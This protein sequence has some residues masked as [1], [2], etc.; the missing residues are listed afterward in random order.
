LWLPFAA[1]YAMSKHGIVAYSGS[2]RLE[3]GDAITVTSVYPGYI[4]TSIHRDSIEF[5]LPL[6]G[7]STEERIEDAVA[8]LTRAALGQPV[9]DITT[10]RSGWF[11]NRLSRHLP[12]PWI[13]RIILS[14]MRRKLR[15]RE[16]ANATGPV[17]EFARRIAAGR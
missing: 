9:R 8:A 10:T 5:G 4:K 1:A 2:L 6:E 17:A 11:T 15:S 14:R 7:T 3:H 12:R 13:D 16:Y